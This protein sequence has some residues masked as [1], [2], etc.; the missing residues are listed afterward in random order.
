MQPLDVGSD[1][2]FAA[3]LPG[4]DMEDDKSLV[5]N[6]FVGKKLL[7]K[8]SQDEGREIYEDREFIQIQIKGQDKQVV[9]EEVKP[10]HKRKFPIAYHL[11]QQGK[12][13]PVVGTPIEQLPGVGPSMA[14]NLKAINLRTIE[15]VANVTDENALSA[16]GMGARDLV[17][18]AKAFI[19]KAA[20]KTVALEE[21]N[22]ALKSQLAGM[23]ESV[24]ALQEQMA[25][26]MA[27][28]KGGRPKKE[29]PQ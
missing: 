2:A 24:R 4:R 26:L 8:K 14:H 5:V 12:P 15:D 6:F 27:K 11:F 21:E 10:E 7:G 18:R 20:P 3:F 17:T 16:M 25:A 13:A 29:T 1:E 28:K 23:E 9:V 22:K 19:A